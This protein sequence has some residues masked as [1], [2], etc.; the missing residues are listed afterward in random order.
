[1]RVTAG[2]SACSTIAKGLLRQECPHGIGHSSQPQRGWEASTCVGPFARGTVTAMAPIS[3]GSSLVLATVAWA[4]GESSQ[5]NV[6]N[7]EL[8]P[9]NPPLSDLS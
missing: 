2:R 3:P 7:L 5:V 1:M 8:Q 6:V 9:G 4:D